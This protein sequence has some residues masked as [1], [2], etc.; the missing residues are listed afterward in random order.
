VPGDTLAQGGQVITVTAVRPYVRRD[1]SASHLIGWQGPDGRVGVS[2][3]VSRDVRWGLTVDE[4]LR[5]SAAARTRRA[6][7][8]D[9][10]VSAKRQALPKARLGIRIDA[11]LA[12]RL[13]GMGN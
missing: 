13:K 9:A 3:L 6:A 12:D 10:D 4:A 1:G 5:L 11:E 8:P 2:G 7:Q